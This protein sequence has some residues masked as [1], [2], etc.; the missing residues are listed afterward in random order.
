VY[1]SL[2]ISPSDLT[3]S[4]LFNRKNGNFHISVASLKVARSSRTKTIWPVIL[5]TVIVVSSFVSAAPFF[6]ALGQTSAAAPSNSVLTMTL[7]G[8]PDS[9]NPLTAPSDCRTCWQIISL[10]YAYGL[11]ELPN[12]SSNLGASLFDTITI[13][14]NATVWNFNIRPN[15]TWSDKIPINSTDVVFTFDEVNNSGIYQS[16]MAGLFSNVK[17]VQTLNDTDTQFVLKTSDSTFGYLLFSQYFFPIL[18][19]HVWSANTTSFFSS[20]YFG[21]DVTS[22]PFYH[23]EYNGGG[24]LMLDANRYYWGAHGPSQIEIFFVTDSSQAAYSVKSFQSDLAEIDPPQVSEFSNNASFSVVAEPDRAMT[25]MEYNVS[26][27]PFNN[28]AFREALAYLVNT[29]AISQT[30]YE[31]YATPGYLGRGMI[32]PSEATWHN[33]STLQ[34]SYSVSTANQTLHN[35]NFS[36]SNNKWYTPNGTPI[37]ITIFTD[38]NNTNDN[39]TA[40]MVA[41]DLAKL[42]FNASVVIY[43]TNELTAAYETGVG[44]V[45]LGIV[46]E[47]ATNPVFGLG[48]LDVQPAY[49]TYYP[50]NVAEPA[51][52]T[53]QQYNSQYE[54]LLSIADGST[55]GSNVQSAIQLMDGL[56]S[57]YLPIIVLNYPDTVWVYGNF[58]ATGFAFSNSASSIDMGYN[59]LNPAAFSALTCS[60]NCTTITITSLSIPTR[61]PTSTAT[62]TNSISTSNTTATSTP[63]STVSNGG[64][65]DVDLAASIVVVLVLIALGTAY[66]RTH[67]PKPPPVSQ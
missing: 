63:G 41:Q 16:A 43:P 5:F 53:P 34:Y 1:F 52:I 51:W 14:P 50:W 7:I 67:K 49:D 30:L 56:N 6:K 11:S 23:A 36:F 20:D 57:Q 4:L 48:F 35:A 25:Y 12:G 29:S 59:F 3:R 9:L 54:S 44:G 60:G 26:Q 18:P 55:S 22:G 46:I 65:S 24:S 8:S 61:L 47:T 19:E 32:P 38:S 10:E 13:S 62:T 17:S 28:P 37:S 64:A 21:Q 58:Q 15:A 39:A 27:V 66:S 42:D 45:S 40:E 31:G 33:S 2:T